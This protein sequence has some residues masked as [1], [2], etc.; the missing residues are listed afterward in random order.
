M[1]S[2]RLK[3]F[4]LNSLAALAAWNAATGD[5]DLLRVIAGKERNQELSKM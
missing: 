4:S 2:A 5:E 3:T 1:L